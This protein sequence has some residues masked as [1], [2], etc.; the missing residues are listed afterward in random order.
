V[1]SLSNREGHSPATIAPEGLRAGHP[2]LI[3]QQ[4]RIAPRLARGDPPTEEFIMPLPRSTA[5]T[6][7]LALALLAFAAAAPARAEGPLTVSVTNY[8][9]IPAGA[10]YVT[11]LNQNTELTSN[12]ESL[13]REALA[14]RGLDYDLNGMLGFKIGTD[15]TGGVR[16]PDAV[17]DSSNTVL[18]L[19]LNS[20]DVKGA[21]RLGHTYRVSLSIYDRASGHVLARGSASDDMPDADPFG[22]T[23]PMIEKI[24]DGMQF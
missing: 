10:T 2:G 24:L 16:P 11:D 20:G 5:L 6:G 3:Y 9:K 4:C 19:N 12:A 23:K 1:A 15:H 18:H 8:D 22:V 17:F 21:P 7:L 13:L 14:K